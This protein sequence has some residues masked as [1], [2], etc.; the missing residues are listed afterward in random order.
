MGRIPEGDPEDGG[1]LSPTVHYMWPHHRKM[2][3]LAAA[4]LRPAEIA[5]VTGF[6]L[7][8]I[9]RILGSPLFQ[10]EVGRL[11]AQADE[12]AVDIRVDLE[13][14]AG[15]A[16]EN[17]A[18]DIN[19]EIS[20]LAERKVRQAA[21]FDVLNRTGYGKRERPT[22]GELHLHKHDEVHVASMSDKELLDEVLD[23]TAEEE[24][25]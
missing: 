16:V 12:R 2:A 1:Y 8:Q 17:I 19:L 15:A 3:R 5:T 14:L 22:F 10:T 23:L 7:G 25:T 9:S 4:G 21:S 24:A 18:E 11:E 20:N 6:S 13:K